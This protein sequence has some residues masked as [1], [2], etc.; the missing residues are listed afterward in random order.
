MSDLALCIGLKF[1]DPD[2]VNSVLY[3]GI[4]TK[5]VHCTYTL[6]PPYKTVFTAKCIK[7]WRNR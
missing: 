4:K 7:R 3:S 1:S 5:E 6:C 2:P